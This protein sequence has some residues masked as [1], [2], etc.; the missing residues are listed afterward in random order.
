[1]AAIFFFFTI[2]TL[3]FGNFNQEDDMCINILYITLFTFESEGLCTVVLF[4][5]MQVKQSKSEFYFI[6]RSSL[7]IMCG[8]CWILDEID[9]I[10]IGY[11]I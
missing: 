3:R 6:Y 4:K 5:Y 8:I 11:S 10:H 9:Y 1:M 7:W 2:V